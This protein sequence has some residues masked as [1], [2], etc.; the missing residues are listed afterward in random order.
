MSKNGNKIVIVSFL[1]VFALYS[2]LSFF[3]TDIGVI[4]EKIKSELFLALGIGAYAVPFLLA[5]L[6]YEIAVLNQSRRYKFI[7]RIIGLSLWF[8]IFLTLVEGKAAKSQVSFSE[9]HLGGKAGNSF[10]LLLSRYLG[11]GGTLLALLLFAFLGTYLLGEGKLIRQM[12]HLTKSLR[13]KMGK[14]QERTSLPNQTSKASVSPQS[15]LSPTV[16]EVFEVASFASKET[17]TSKK[18]RKTLPS[19]EET[20]ILPS[21]KIL[22]SRPSKGEEKSRKEIAEEIAKLEKT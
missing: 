18:T 12:V 6:A 8:T 19:E 7:G 15:T 11:N 2:F 9:Y 17:G 20:W 3:S 14:L 4:G 1:S 21:S 16:E 10:Y 5:Y 13:R 22:S